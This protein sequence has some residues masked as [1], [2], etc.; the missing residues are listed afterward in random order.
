MNAVAQLRHACGL[1]QTQFANRLGVSMRTVVAFEKD[2]KEPGYREVTKKMAERMMIEFSALPDSVLSGS[3][4]PLTIAGEPYSK[5]SYENLV[6]GIWEPPTVTEREAMLALG[7]KA[8]DIPKQRHIEKKRK[9]AESDFEKWET[10]LIEKSAIHLRWL[11]EAS[12]SHG[13]ME[14]AVYLF[15]NWKQQTIKELGITKQFAALAESQKK[16][17][18]DAAPLFVKGRNFAFKVARNTYS[19]HGPIDPIDST[20]KRFNDLKALGP[21]SD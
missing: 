2:S 3:P 13:R 12:A 7:L 16:L 17:P 10:E 21:V 4:K 1:T 15:E 18:L 8:K 6:K 11:I 9:L 5:T 19:G 20:G 14:S